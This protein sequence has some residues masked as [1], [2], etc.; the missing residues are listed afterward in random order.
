GKRL[1]DTA[2]AVL[3]N[4]TS[5]FA[6]IGILLNGKANAQSND[7]IS[8][9]SL[10]VEG[11][12]KTL[13]TDTAGNLVPIMRTDIENIDPEENIRYLAASGDI[14]DQ[15]PYEPKSERF[16]NHRKNCV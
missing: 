9:D 2:A 8:Y 12:D 1:N 3:S 7:E 14:N 6:S 10:Y 4:P 13:A 15:E 16:K 11:V 5:I